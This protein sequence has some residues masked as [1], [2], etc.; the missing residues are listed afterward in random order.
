MKAQFDL[1]VTTPEERG[2][3]FGLAVKLPDTC[4][5]N[6]DVVRIGAPCGPHLAELRCSHCERHR[7]WLPREA[8]K[9]ITEIISNFGRPTEPIAIRRGNQ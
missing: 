4:R 8:H 1:F 6:S 3:L 9:F 7:G 2:P 5:C